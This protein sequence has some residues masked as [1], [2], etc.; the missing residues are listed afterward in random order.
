MPKKTFTIENLTEEQAEQLKH[1]EI[2]AKS[3]SLLEK[4]VDMV[5]DPK[6]SESLVSGCTISTRAVRSLSKNNYPIVSCRVKFSNS[7]TTGQGKKL[8][9]PCHHVMML[10]KLRKTDKE[11]PLWSY[12]DD[13]DVV[14]HNCHNTHCYKHLS[15]TTTEDNN[16]KNIHC[17]GYVECKNCRVRIEVCEHVPKCI[18]YKLSICTKCK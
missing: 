14:N 15:I 11:A 8:T 6:F 10:Y 18:P 1:M 12:E 4:V 5:K 3:N 2:L 16:S 13:D 17:F 9:L 7:P